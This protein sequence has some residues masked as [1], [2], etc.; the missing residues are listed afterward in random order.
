V[1][2]V[3]LSGPSIINQLSGL[4]PHMYTSPPHIAPE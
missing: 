2:E 4:S 1:G 3:T